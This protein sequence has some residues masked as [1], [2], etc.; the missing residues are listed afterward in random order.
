LAFVFTAE[1]ARGV[2]DRL[3]PEDVGSMFLR[4]TKLYNLHVLT[5]Q[6]V[7]NVKVNLSVYVYF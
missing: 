5:T 7:V 4:N 1:E 3:N 2:V 6:I